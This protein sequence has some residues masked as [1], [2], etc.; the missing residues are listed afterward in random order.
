MNLITEAESLAREA[1]DGQVDKAGQP[2][3]THP[4]RVADRVAGDDELVA[5]AWLH[6]V[7]EDTPITLEDLRHRGFPETVV[8]AVD[9]LTKRDDEPKADYYA[10]VAANGRALKVKHADLADNSDPE[11]L[12]A[13][14]RA[15]RERLQEKYRNARRLL[16]AVNG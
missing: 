1:H 13:L 7:V 2:Y 8:A 3:A 10:R 15:T 14:D 5:I 6:D 12:A 16:P 4:A 11:R 9:A